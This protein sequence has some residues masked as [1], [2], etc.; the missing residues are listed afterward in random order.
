MVRDSI[1]SVMNKG[2]SVASSANKGKFKILLG[3]HSFVFSGT[4][5]V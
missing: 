1:D 2:D 3:L 5:D 4:A